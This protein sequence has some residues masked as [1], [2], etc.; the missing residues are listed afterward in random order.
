MASKTDEIAGAPTVAGSVAPGAGNSITIHLTVTPD[1]PNDTKV[2]LGH[3]FEN[4]KFGPTKFDGATMKF[5]HGI[6]YQDLPY[7]ARYFEISSQDTQ[8]STASRVSFFKGGGSTEE[9]QVAFF[10]IEPGLQISTLTKSPMQ[11][12]V[13]DK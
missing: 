10:I 11:W 3:G 12:L 4:G 13:G 9:D 8:S 5:L 2:G 6:T 7:A 1:W